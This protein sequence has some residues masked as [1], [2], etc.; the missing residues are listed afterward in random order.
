MAIPQDIIDEII[1]AVGDDKPSL[2]NCALV[3]SSFLLPCRRRLWREISLSPIT[4]D[5]KGLRQLFVQNPVLQS[6]V[7]S[8]TIGITINLGY[9]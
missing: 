8:I 3:S 7:T 5:C 9:R 2:K 1:E 6:F 4:S